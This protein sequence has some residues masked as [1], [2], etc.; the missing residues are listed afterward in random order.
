MVVRKGGRVGGRGGG[1]MKSFE[2]SQERW[3]SKS[4]KGGAEGPNFGHFVRT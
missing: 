3:I 4:N 1:L 2:H